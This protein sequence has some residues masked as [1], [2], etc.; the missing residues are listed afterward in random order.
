MSGGPRVVIDPLDDAAVKAL[1]E[2]LE[3]ARQAAIDPDELASIDAAY[4]RYFDQVLRTPAD[5]RQDPT[6]TLTTIA[7]AMGEHL[8]RHSALHWRVVKDAEGTD[9]ALASADDTGVLFPVDPVADA[10]SKQQRDW[11]ADFVTEVLS[12]LEAASQ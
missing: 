6:Q 5:H 10:W 9:L 4:A 7:M 3:R 12:E 8:Q 11:L 1:H 2:W